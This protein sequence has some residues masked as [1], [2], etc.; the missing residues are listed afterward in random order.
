MTPARTKAREEGTVTYD[1]R[2]AEYWDVEDLRKE[3]ERVFD[4]C[5]GCRRCYNL[6]PSFN[7]L[8]DTLDEQ[9]VE[10]EELA[11]SVYDEVVD[12]CYQCKL[13][14]PHCPYTPPHRWQIDF[15][16]LMLRARAVRARREGVSFPDKVLGKTDLIGKVGTRLSALMNWANRNRLSRFVMERITGIHRGRNLPPYAAQSFARWFAARKPEPPKSP[17]ARVALFETCS[18]NYNYTE[19]GKAAV[20]VLAHNEVEVV[21]PSQVCC[22]MPALDGGDTDEALRKI[23]ANIASLL[24]WVEK[25]YDIVVPGP[26]CSYMLKKEYPVLHPSPESE[27]IASHTFDLCEYLMK[28]REAGKLKTDFKHAPGKITYQLPC[29]LRVQNIGFKSRDLLSTIP[30]AQVRMIERCSAVDGTWGLKKEYYETSLELAGKLFQEVEGEATELVVSDCS[31]AGLQITQGTKRKV[32]H[33]IEVVA[34]A[35]GLIE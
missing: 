11:P 28:L 32:L 12:L 19:V 33:P 9:E 22:G 15:P 5:H 8:L 35:Y 1:L 6:C 24:P 18:V 27:R 25:G 30:G 20:A 29:H 31:L 3:M 34:K 26:T 4:I 13:C 7:V 17:V 23:R 16:R 14:D 2:K 10:V 21:R